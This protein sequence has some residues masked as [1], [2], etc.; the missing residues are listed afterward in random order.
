[1]GRASGLFVTHAQ[2][3]GDSDV[4]DVPTLHFGIA[5]RRKAIL[6]HVGDGDWNEEA[7]PPVAVAMQ[8]SWCQ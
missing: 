1:M 7:N 8:K 6:R 2:G 3:C 4:W 5:L